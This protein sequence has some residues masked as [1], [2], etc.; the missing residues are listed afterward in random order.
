MNKPIAVDCSF[1]KDGRV[2]VRRVAFG[3]SWQVVEQ[4]RQWGDEHGR[5]VLIMIPGGH[6]QEIILSPETLNW[7]LVF[8][9]TQ[10]NI[11]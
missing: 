7:K 8:D 2:L 10:T 1:E 5:H 6:V 11:A 4:G 3:D 9:R